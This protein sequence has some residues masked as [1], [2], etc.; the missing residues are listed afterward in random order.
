VVETKEADGRSTRRIGPVS[1]DPALHA[2]LFDLWLSDPENA[3]KGADLEPAPVD[4][5]TTSG[6]GLDPHITLRNALSVYQLDRV[7][8]R[9]TAP[10]GD[11]A[12]TRADVERLARGQSFIPLSGMIGEPLVNVLE[13]NV[14]LDERF[15]TP[16]RPAHAP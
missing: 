5:V 13:L 12:K 14:A 15:T 6:S 4:M 8:A 11:V 1:S 7:A 3:K 2:N 10:G 16:T 9:R